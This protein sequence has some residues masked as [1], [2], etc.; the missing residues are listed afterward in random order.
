MRLLCA[1]TALGLFISPAL[2]QTPAEKTYN[3]ALSP[4]DMALVI[5]A[6]PG[7]T[8]TLGFTAS[9]LGSAA[10]KLQRHPY[11]DVADVLNRIQA[12]IDAQDKAAATPPSAVAAPATGAPPLP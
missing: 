6:L 7:K 10:R 5:R 11:E 12:Q 3:L 4:E 8:Y 1:A 9:E 2:A